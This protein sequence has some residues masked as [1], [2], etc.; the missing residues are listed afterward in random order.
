MDLC[1]RRAVALPSLDACHQGRHPPSLDL[2]VD[3]EDD[4]GEERSSEGGERAVLAGGVLCGAGGATRT[5]YAA[6]EW[7]RPLRETP[8]DSS[9][10]GRGCPVTVC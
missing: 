2:G 6:G 9:T 1:C 3:G 10:G 5:W 4:G 8:A 7:L